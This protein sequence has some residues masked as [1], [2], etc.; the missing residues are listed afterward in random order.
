MGYGLRNVP[1][2]RQSI[3]EIHRVLRPGGLALSLDFNLP[4]N[5]LIRAVYLGYLKVVGGALG[6]LLHRDADTYRYIPA[7]IHN[8]PGAEGVARMFETRGFGPVEHYRVLGGLL[9]IHRAR[10]PAVAG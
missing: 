10:K 2:L 9:T 3:A 7:S 1:D 5:R 8:Y 4:S 6:Y